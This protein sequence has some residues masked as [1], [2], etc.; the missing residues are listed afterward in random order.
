MKNLISALDLL[1]YL[2]SIEDRVC[3]S[4]VFHG[5]LINQDGHGNFITLNFEIVVGLIERII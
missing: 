4:P 1:R 2:S 5:E 3:G